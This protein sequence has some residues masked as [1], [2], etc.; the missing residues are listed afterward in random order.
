MF[1]HVESF[2]LRRHRCI[3]DS[4]VLKGEIPYVPGDSMTCRMPTADTTRGH[5]IMAIDCEVPVRTA[6]TDRRLS[7]TGLPPI[8]APGQGGEIHA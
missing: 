1:N 6:V 2:P 4:A 7:C 3:D 8:P 5:Y